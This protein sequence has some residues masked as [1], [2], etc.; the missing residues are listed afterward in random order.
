MNI[1]S[2]IFLL[3]GFVLSDDILYNHTNSDNNLYFVF[4]TFR[5]GARFSFGRQ[6]IF[7]NP[8]SSPGSLTQYGAIQHLEIGQKY[9][10]RYSNFLDMNFDKNQFYIRTT[11]V[12]RTIISAEKQLE[13]LFNKSIGRSIFDIQRGGPNC[14]NLYCIT[15]EERKE[16]DKY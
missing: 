8:I 7:G 16:L 12:E 6:D 1:I 5:H 10:E 15:I 2:F 4:T 11:D 9:R 14:W 3:F 13:G